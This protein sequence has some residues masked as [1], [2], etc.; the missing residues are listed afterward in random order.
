MRQARTWQAQRP[1]SRAWLR[2]GPFDLPALNR[3]LHR[4]R[5]LQCQIR[6]RGICG[7]GAP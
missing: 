7:I 6:K 2:E 5:G 3:A 1:V 4:M